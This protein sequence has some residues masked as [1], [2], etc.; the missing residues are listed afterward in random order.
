MF[1]HAQAGFNI[2]S[3]KTYNIHPNLASVTRYS[4]KI[5]YYSCILKFPFYRTLTISVA[6]IFL[7][8]SKLLACVIQ[9]FWQQK[10]QTT[11][12]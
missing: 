6:I 12:S 5:P 3:H 4:Q 2:Q 9:S 11:I 10:I 1:E 7:V 8:I